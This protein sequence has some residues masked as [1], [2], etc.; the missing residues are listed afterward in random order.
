MINKMEENIEN[1]F[2]KIKVNQ[3]KSEETQ[4]GKNMEIHPQ[5]HL[6]LISILLLCQIDNVVFT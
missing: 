3:N 1:S 4:F 6:A 2:N 5:E